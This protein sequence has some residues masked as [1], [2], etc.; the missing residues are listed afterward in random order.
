MK[1]KI[2]NKKTK[3]I[4]ESVV[5]QKYNIKYYQCESCNFIQTEDPYWLDEAYS[6]SIANMDVGYV[7]RNVMYSQMIST[8]IKLYFNKDAK[9]LD[10]GGG[11]GLFVRLM[12]DRGFQFFRQDLYSDNL[13][14]TYFDIE[15]I[16]G[17]DKF[18]LVTAF[19]M[20][21]HLE[22]PLDDIKKMFEYSDSI[23]F[24]TELQSKK[25]YDSAADWW[26]FVP[27]TGQH[28]SFYTK[29][30]LQVIA[31]HFG[32]NVYSNSRDLHL[33]THKKFRVN[34]T[35]L[36]YYMRKLTD[37]IFGLNFSNRNSLI[38]HDFEKAKQLTRKDEQ[39]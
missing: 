13:F 18:E 24:S 17:N 37:K 11:Y 21:E 19:E 30:S 35:M 14:S 3:E 20:F 38:S 22:N 26:Y 7:T 39:N 23:L 27:E 34:P 36:P 8:L 9:Y 31:D 12:R 1:C 10:Y 15:D 4:F 28:I 6:Q 25:H 32:C 16:E 29:Q 5:I 2:C 33:L